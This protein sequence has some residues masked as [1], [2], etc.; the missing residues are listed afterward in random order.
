MQIDNLHIILTAG[1]FVLSVISGMLGLGVA[2][3]AIPFLG[4]FLQ[5]L[6]HQI[7]PLSLLLNGITALLATLGFAKSGLVDWKRAI[8]LSIVTTVFAPVGA[9]IVQFIEQKYVWFVYFWL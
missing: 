7:Q 4:L 6:I 9:Y 1:L 3:A 8:V 5:D 2:F